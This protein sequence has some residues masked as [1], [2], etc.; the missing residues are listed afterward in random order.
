[1]LF[2]IIK[3]EI[4]G[5][6][7]FDDRRTEWIRVVINFVLG[8]SLCIL[9]QTG[10]D[11]TTERYKVDEKVIDRIKILTRSSGTSQLGKDFVVERSMLSS[12]I[13][14]TQHVVDED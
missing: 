4:S 14:F 12:D 7:S 8:G 9:A 1:M 2:T 3:N 6:E 13:L 10:T 11:V 5:N